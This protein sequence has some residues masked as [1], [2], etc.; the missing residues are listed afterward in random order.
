MT[1]GRPSY[2]IDYKQ[3]Y[4]NVELRILFAHTELNVTIVML[5][6]CDML[7]DQV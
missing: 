6:R 5:L 2:T 1:Y 3:E 4:N 7:F